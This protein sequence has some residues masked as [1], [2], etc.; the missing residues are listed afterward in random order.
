[1]PN[2]LS[3]Y[4]VLIMACIFYAPLIPISL[5]IA[6]CGSFLTYMSYKYMLLRV[7][8]MPEM[9]GDLMATFFA[10]LMPLILVVWALSYWIFVRE[11]NRAFQP[12]FNAMYNCDEA[13]NYAS[14]GVV[15]DSTNSDPTNGASSL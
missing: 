13:N 10:S 1:M 15:I 8:K 14:C 4:F 6:C 9:F 3:K 11:I 12:K 2:I 5:P 7:H